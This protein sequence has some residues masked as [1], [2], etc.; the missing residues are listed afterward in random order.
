[1]HGIVWSISANP[2][3]SKFNAA[4]CLLLFKKPDATYRK[5]STNLWCYAEG[6]NISVFLCS[7]SSICVCKEKRGGR[8][9]TFSLL[10]KKN[11]L[12]DSWGG[13]SFNR[14]QERKG[15]FISGIQCYLPLITK[16]NQTDYRTKQI[17]RRLVAGRNAGVQTEHFPHFL[18]FLFFFCTYH[19][20]VYTE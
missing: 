15:N 2:F 11:L 17:L 20:Q 9:K 13:K 6:W 18:L 19:L 7:F 10:K 1:M 3:L 5:E 12:L 8:L 4:P 14:W 16:P